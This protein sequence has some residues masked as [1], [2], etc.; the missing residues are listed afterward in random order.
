[1]VNQKLGSNNFRNRF[2]DTLVFSWQIVNKK[3]FKYELTCSSNILDKCWLPRVMIWLLGTKTGPW[4]Y[5]GSE[6]VYLPFIIFSYI[7]KNLNT[8][9]STYLQ[10]AQKMKNCLKD[11]MIIQGNC[12]LNFFLLYNWFI[13]K[14][15]RM[16]CCKLEKHCNK[17]FQP[18]V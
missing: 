18:I 14:I 15:F 7:Q 13:V 10:L 6:N 2:F 4:H 12:Y 8:F 5:I 16:F 11:L 17:G 9:S 1:M 3:K